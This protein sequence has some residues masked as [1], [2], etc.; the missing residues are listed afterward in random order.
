MHRLFL[1]IALD[2]AARS[3]CESIAA[4]LERGG[5][6]GSFVP[7]ENYHVTL[8]FLGNVEPPKIASISQ[9]CAAIA[10]RHKPFAIT[11]DRVGAFPH[12]HRPRI[13]FVGSRGTDPT[14]RALAADLREASAVRGFAVEE[15]DDVPH[16]TLARVREKRKTALP[17]IDVAPFTF[18]VEQLTLFESV[19]YEGR[20]GYR[21]REGYLLASAV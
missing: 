11:F 16:V 10:E 19:P 18:H 4:R 9:A 21:S 17:M 7:P 2:D 6:R 14:Y 3:A 20:T 13:V 12:E 8:L 15:K 1:G 5:L